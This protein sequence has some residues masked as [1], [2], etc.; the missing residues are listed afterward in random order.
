MIAPDA[1]EHLLKCWNCCT[2]MMVL[3]EA[4]KSAEPAERQL[5]RIQTRIVQDLRPVRPLA[6]SPFL[7]FMYATI[8]LC[9]VTIG[10]MPFAMSGWDALSMAQRIVV[11]A[12]L[13]GSAALLSISM[14]G[15]MAP[16][17]R[18]SLAP[19]RLPSAI[20]AALMLAIA[21]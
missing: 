8:F 18:Y 13:P 16:G 6:P 14:V 10:A 19:E 4:G 17:S 12:P 11:F 3:Q 7:L 21:A 1:V 5:K 9:I 20:L 2:L 15:Q